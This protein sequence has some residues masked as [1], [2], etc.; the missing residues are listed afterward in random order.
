MR[1][2]GGPICE[3]E[4]HRKQGHGTATLKLPLPAAKSSVIDRCICYVLR[5]IGQL[6]SSAVRMFALAAIA[7]PSTTRPGI[8]HASHSTTFVIAALAGSDGWDT[9]QSWILLREPFEA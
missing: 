9:V 7:E 2:R 4:P 6:H 5:Q 3:K 8:A 1:I